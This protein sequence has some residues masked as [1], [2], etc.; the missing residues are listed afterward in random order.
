MHEYTG[1]EDP[2]RITKGEL[3]SKMLD[4]RFRKLIT[5][6][7]N[8][9]EYKFSLNMYENGSCPDVGFCNFNISL[10]FPPYDLV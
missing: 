5:V 3:I 1:R 6:K 2:M 10:L 9:H 7:R 4:E 8:V